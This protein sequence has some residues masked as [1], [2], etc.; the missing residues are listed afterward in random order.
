[1]GKYVKP[2]SIEIAIPGG[3]SREQVID[4]LCEA[5][6]EIIDDM[7]DSAGVDNCSTKST[8]IQYLLHSMIEAGHDSCAKSACLNGMVHTMT[9]V[10]VRQM[11][12]W[13]CHQNLDN[14]YLH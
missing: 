14:P 2:N 8:A 6:V 9:E 5:V 7:A 11:L 4:I 13:A 3:T 1:M 12:R 10:Q